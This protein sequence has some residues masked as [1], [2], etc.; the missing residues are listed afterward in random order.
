MTKTLDSYREKSYIILGQTKKRSDHGYSPTSS[1]KLVDTHKDK[2]NPDRK[3]KGK[4]VAFRI[5]NTSY[6]MSV[7]SAAR[8][9]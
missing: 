5:S 8:K 6:V 7:Q 3:S 1:K 4:E 9:H 2:M